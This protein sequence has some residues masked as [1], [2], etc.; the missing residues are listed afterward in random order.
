MYEEDCRNCT[1][2]SIFTL[3]VGRMG[4]RTDLAT[5]AQDSKTAGS[6]AHFAGPPALQ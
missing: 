3:N 4:Q 5:E 1:L 6:P 2:F